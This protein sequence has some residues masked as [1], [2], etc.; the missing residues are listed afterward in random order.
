MTVEMNSIS[1]TRD[2]ISNGSPVANAGCDL[3]KSDN[4]VKNGKQHDYP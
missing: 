3:S 4:I 1:D 2:A